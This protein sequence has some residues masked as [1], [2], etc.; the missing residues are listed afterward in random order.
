MKCIK[1]QTDNKLRERTAN[2]GRCKNCQHPF[3]FDPKGMTGITFT[4]QFFANCISS[5]SAQDTLFF[6]PRQL[7]YAFNARKANSKT[8]FIL[9]CIGL[10]AA[11]VIL[12]SAG[13]PFFFLLALLLVGAGFSLLLPPVQKRLRSKKPKEPAVTFDQ[14]GQWLDRWTK[15]NGPLVKLLPPPSP[16]KAPARINPE[17]A[18]YSFDRVVVCQ[19][20]AVAQFLI[21]NNFHF[22]HNCAVLSLEKYPQDIFDTVMQMLRRNPELKVYALHD[23]S[24]GGVQMTHELL[25]D[26]AWFAD[27]GNVKI[28]DLG[29]L[30]RQLIDHPAFVLEDYGKLV[31]KVS[32]MPAPVR[33]ALQPAEVKWL[34]ERKYVEVESLGPQRLLRLI[35]AGIAQSRDPNA[36]DT[37]VPV[38]GGDGGSG[39]YIYSIDSFG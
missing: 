22:E 12:A 8:P 20:A 25:T 18:A 30:P 23:A 11:A 32:A 3:A 37:L 36:A 6:T 38:E 10:S 4:D 29:L 17:V 39:V 26:P 1:C 35:T 2:D 13:G 21:A 15:I 16:R 9:G 14:F 27:F 28:F 19:H 34:E 7:Y 5:V 33:D 31:P 24:P